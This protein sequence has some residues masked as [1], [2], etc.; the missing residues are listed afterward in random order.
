M[1]KR[2]LCLLAVAAATFSAVAQPRVAGSRITDYK[3]VY[4]STAEAEEGFDAARQ[5]QLQIAEATACTLDVV[6]DGDRR[7]GKAIVV[8]NS[9]RC[10]TF[11]YDVRCAGSKL[12]ID[13]G[14]CW[15][16]FKAGK[17]LASSLK[18]GDVKSSWKASGTVE[19]EFLFPIAEGCNLR[20][21][22]DNIWDYSRDTI[23]PAWKALGVDCRDDVRAPQFAALVRAYMPDVLNLQEYNRH[24]HDRFYPL[25]Q[26]YGYEIAYESGN[27]WNNT[28]VF[29][30]TATVELV[31]AN[32]NLYTPKR[33][34]NH[35]SKSFT[36]AVLRHKATGKVFAVINTHLWYKGESAQSGSDNAR[37]AQAHLMMAESDI[38]CSKYNGP[39]F[40]T[41]D[42]N[43][44]EDSLPIQIFLSNG[45]VPCYKAAT[46]YG[47]NHNGHHI[48]APNDG[49]SRKSRRI[50]PEREGGAIDHCLVRDDSGAAE[51]KV[52]DCIQ[53]AFTI[54]LTDHYPN[55]IDIKL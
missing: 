42:M 6:S 14:G 30:N 17:L 20:I 7:S 13:A 11:E 53:A 46:V 19:G 40:V 32:Y 23:P 9:G 55:L 50:S 10:G 8:K 1:K 33:W 2:L 39:V 12:T 51:V 26:Q 37:A 38:I 44:Y 41:G 27:D 43:C 25:I 4:C 18:E 45:Y 49:F 3:I 36:S 48:C 52:F 15:A 54:K 31:K 21:L 24:M 16:M 29:Y 47:D 34:S 28:P 22:D 5:L 35:G